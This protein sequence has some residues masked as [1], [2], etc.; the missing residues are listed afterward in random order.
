MALGK[1]LGAIL[2]EVGDAYASEMAS[3]DELIST[4]MEGLVA[5][6]NI[7][8]IDPNPYQPRK[9]FDNEKLQE[10]AESIQKLWTTTA[11]SSDKK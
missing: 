5:D 4:D 10:L 1:G 2:Q 3:S 9:Y 6:I 11:C 7:D 8:I